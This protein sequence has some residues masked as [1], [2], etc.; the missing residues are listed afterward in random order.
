MDIK[1]NTAHKDDAKA[2]REI[3]LKTWMDTY[4]PIVGKEQVDYMIEEMYT[5]KALQD[6]MENGNEF[7][8][9]WLDDA[10]V[11][12]LSYDKISDERFRIHKLYIH[13]DTHGKG[14]GKLLLDETLKRV[15][16]EN[17]KVI[18]LNV[19]RHNKARFFYEKYG[20][21]VIREEDLPIGKYWMNDYVMEMEI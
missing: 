11:G 7:L 2:I 3:A 14:L 15:R 10:P 17:G 9:C 5:V 12:F 8:I 4:V 6:Q 18:K 13:P 19:N 20:F 21:K 16:L 1:I